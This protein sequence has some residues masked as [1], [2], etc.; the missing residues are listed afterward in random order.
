MVDLCSPES[1][2]LP[3]SF[4][5]DWLWYNST[6]LKK[7]ERHIFGVPYRFWRM[8]EI[9]MYPSSRGGQVVATE[10]HLDKGFIW[11]SKIGLY[12]KGF[13]D[14]DAVDVT[15]LV[16]TVTANKP[17]GGRPSW[18]DSTFTGETVGGVE[19]LI[20]NQPYTSTIFYLDYGSTSTRLQLTFDFGEGNEQIV[21]AITQTGVRLPCRSIESFVLYASNDGENWDKIA[22]YQDLAD[23]IEQGYFPSL[24]RFSSSRLMTR[25]S[26]SVPESYCKSPYNRDKLYNRSDFMAVI[27]DVKNEIV[28]PSE[29]NDQQSEQ[30]QNKFRFF[31]FY[32]FEAKDSDEDRIETD[33]LQLFEDGSLFHH[34]SQFNPGRYAN[35]D[36]QRVY[37]F[38]NPSDQSDSD[39]E[40]EFLDQGVSLS[41]QTGAGGSVGV[42]MFENDRSA[43]STVVGDLNR[44]GYVVDFGEGNEKNITSIRQVINPEAGNLNET[45]Y[46]KSF[47]VMAVNREFFRPTSLVYRDEEQDTI[48]FGET[49]G[50]RGEV[51]KVK[52][53]DLQDPITETNDSYNTPVSSG[54][55]KIVSKHY[56]ML[57]SA[58]DY[59]V[60]PGDAERMWQ[61][62]YLDD[63]LDVEIDSDI[64]DSDFVQSPLPAGDVQ[65]LVYNDSDKLW[66][67]QT[68]TV[69][70][71]GGGGALWEWNNTPIL[72]FST[73]P[74]G[75]IVEITPDRGFYHIIDFRKGGTQEGF[76]ETGITYYKTPYD[77]VI[78]LP[79]NPQ[80][81]DTVIY[82]ILYPDGYSDFDAQYNEVIVSTEEGSF[83][84]IDGKTAFGEG[85]CII[86]WEADP[87]QSS[88]MPQ[89]GFTSTRLQA[90]AGFYYIG[91]TVGWYV[92]MG[93]VKHQVEGAAS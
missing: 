82:R 78:R 40:R 28:F 16:Q 68:I 8:G 58:S 83:I 65:T 76:K 23:P 45:R 26:Y 54:R 33:E 22:T 64:G 57:R 14:C 87:D 9:K 56:V 88:S 47:K 70:A 72:P 86:A 17:V 4:L 43:G 53:K 89:S 71:G 37:S 30:R 1:D 31:V 44:R 55:R 2:Y 74:F 92:F 67:N 12:T 60:F 84:P 73:S 24:T 5:P 7:F 51:L 90:H 69:G 38:Q 39:F 46:L 91:G 61:Y 49:F 52:F 59:A 34:G 63:L 81:G 36:I 6:D 66:R 48:Y 18:L 77:T 75:G 21:S 25:P 85:T 93:A 27:R 19:N 15:P 35:F 29:L 11:L 10:T 80:V 62:P 32:S 13:T 42:R 3:D 20:D 41:L 50:D 79:P